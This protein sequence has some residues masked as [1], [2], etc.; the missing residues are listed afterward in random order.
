MLD[1]D[2]FV[3]LGLNQRPTFFGCDTNTS[4]GPLIVY[5]PNAPY[6]YHSNVSTFDLEYSDD[7]RDEIIRNGYNVATMGNGTVDSD[8]LAC[9]GCAVLA[10]SLVRTGTDI[11]A[12]CVD[13]FG[14]Y[15][16]NGTTNSTTPT[17]YEPEQIIT[18][19]ARRSAA[20]VGGTAFVVCMVLLLTA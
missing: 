3:N 11:P 10:R 9:V 7:E 13:C 8:W 20:W 4:S 15:C 6:T 1:Q 14:R 19:G 17:T 2:T 18:S 12:K 5:L 16:W